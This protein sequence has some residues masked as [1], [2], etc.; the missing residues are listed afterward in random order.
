M[1]MS[2]RQDT[3]DPSQDLESYK[4]SAQVYRCQYLET[5]LVLVGHII[6]APHRA[7]GT[8]IVLNENL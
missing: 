4:G 6:D 2:T 1:R 8:G 5:P 7:S 3:N